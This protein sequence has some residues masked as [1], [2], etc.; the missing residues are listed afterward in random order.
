MSCMSFNSMKVTQNLSF[1]EFFAFRAIFSPLSFSPVSLSLDTFFLL[2]SC[3]KKTKM[4]ILLWSVNWNWMVVRKHKTTKVAAICW[5]LYAVKI[6][7]NSSA[8]SIETIFTREMQMKCGIMQFYCLFCE[9]LWKSFLLST[10]YVLL[11]SFSLCLRHWQAP[12]IKRQLDSI[13][14]RIFERISLAIQ[15]LRATNILFARIQ[16][17]DKVSHSENHTQNHIFI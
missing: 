13:V 6:A 1:N 14:K 4:W 16:L 17:A 3:E 8:N 12:E 15:F 7:Q 10:F 9:F 2:V 11:L 5:I